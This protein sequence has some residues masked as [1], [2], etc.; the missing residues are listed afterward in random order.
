[1]CKKAQNSTEV[2]DKMLNAHKEIS[3]MESMRHKNI[4]N[5]LSFAKR[6]RYNTAFGNIIEMQQK[7][8]FTINKNKNL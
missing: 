6:R 4:I 1:M 3:K 2:G 5:S 7:L 8:V